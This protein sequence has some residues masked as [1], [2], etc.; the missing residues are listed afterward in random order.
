MKPT[1]SIRA[2]HRPVEPKAIDMRTLQ[3]LPNVGPSIAGDLRRLG[4]A[5]PRDLAGQDPLVMYH[6]LCA[7]TNARQDPCVLDVF[8]SVVRFMDGAPA[9]PWW[10][11]TAERKRRR[12][13]VGNMASS[14]P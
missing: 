5:V 12:L 4:Y 14:I 9:R 6:R 11:Y 8:I 7:L 1:K 13:L 3:Q 10:F 2:K